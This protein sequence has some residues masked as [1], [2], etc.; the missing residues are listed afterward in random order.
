MQ[1]LR[2]RYHWLG[3]SAA[4]VALVVGLS[5]ST[6]AALGNAAHSSSNSGF[7]RQGSG[8]RPGGGF[9]GY[10]G[11]GGAG[12]GFGANQAGTLPAATQLNVVASQLG[13]T[14]QAL[15]QERASGKTL[16]QIIGEHRATVDQV[17]A[18]LVAQSTIRLDGEV[19]AGRL[20]QQQETQALAQQQRQDRTAIA[21]DSLGT[22]QPCVRLWA[23]A[24]EAM[25]RSRSGISWP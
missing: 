4:I 1:Q 23:I 16:T 24:V 8:Q 9:G 7:G 15:Q 11:F 17:V 3:V 19:A 2:I 5:L 13:I 20:T 10:G 18:A 22:N 6:G 21:N 14:V 12:R 25:R